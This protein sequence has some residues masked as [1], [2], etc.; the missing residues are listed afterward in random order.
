MDR[1]YRIVLTLVVLFA[2]FYG[3]EWFTSGGETEPIEVAVE[4]IREG[5]SVIDVRTA[6]EYDGGHIEGAIH[7][8]V[9][10]DGFRDAVADLDRDEPVYLYCQS[11]HRSG[12]AAAVLEGMGFAR[13]VNV[14]G[15]GAL[16]EGG[17]PIAR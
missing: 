12:R 2:V 4:S 9:L 5:A 7:A 8:N 13:V 1:V 6:S 16:E 15:I 17:L 10:G 3:F 14:G 11:G